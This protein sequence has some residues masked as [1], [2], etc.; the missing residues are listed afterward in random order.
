MTD[1]SYQ[2]ILYV[3]PDDAIPISIII[4]EVADATAAIE[5]IDT[6]YPNHAL[7]SLER[8]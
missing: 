3:C 1:L 6:A 5:V 8:Q 2:A 4:S 7:V